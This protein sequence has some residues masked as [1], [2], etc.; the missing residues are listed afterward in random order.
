MVNDM[1]TLRN[2]MDRLVDEAIVGGPFRT[3]WARSGN[4]TVQAMPLNLYTT[5]DEA[6][7]LAAVPG[8]HPDD[9]ELTVHQNTVTLGGRTADVAQS[10][11]GKGATWYVHELP[12]GQF[13]RSVTLPF[14]INTDQAEA[15]FEHGILRI[16]LPKAEQAKPRR[17]QIQA[18]QQPQAVG[19]GTSTEAKSEQ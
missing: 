12:S 9:L 16:V 8:M 14:E 17:I 2:A 15:S 10:E 18:G 5:E 1:L 11:E 13:R 4:G 6:V 3:V 19:A 7:I